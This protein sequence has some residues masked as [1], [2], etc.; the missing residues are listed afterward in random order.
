MNI[1]KDKI[2]DFRYT[3]DKKELKID[4]IFVK[5]FNDDIFF[6]P[7][8]MI[9]FVKALIERLHEDTA[10]GEFSNELTIPA[11]VDVLEITKALHN[12]I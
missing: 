10:E 6:R 2:E 8:N 11:L 9:Q 5:Y 12:L 7:P 3:V 4:E 1:F